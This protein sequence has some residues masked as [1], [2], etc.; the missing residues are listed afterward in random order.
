MGAG[1]T[2]IGTACHPH[3]S[4]LAVLIV[5]FVLVPGF[6]LRGLISPDFMTAVAVGVVD[7]VLDGIGWLW[8]ALRSGFVILGSWL[9]LVL[10]D[11]MVRRRRTRRSRPNGAPGDTSE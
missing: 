10:A 1:P 11:L 9:T 5:S 2:S 3:R 7:F 6:G 8:L 4:S